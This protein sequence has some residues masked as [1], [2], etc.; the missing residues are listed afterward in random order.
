MKITELY[1]L[2]IRSTPIIVYLASNATWPGSPHGKQT[3]TEGERRGRADTEKTCE[4]L[5]RKAKNKPPVNA[6]HNHALML[7]NPSGEPDCLQEFWIASFCVTAL[8]PAE[9]PRLAS[10]HGVILIIV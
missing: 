6:T 10:R 7:G 1:R 8:D 4:V 5:S 2:F 9:A 3:D